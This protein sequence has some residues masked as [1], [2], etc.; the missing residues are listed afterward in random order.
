[1]PL[2]RSAASSWPS[3]VRAGM[4]IAM[5]ERRAGRGGPRRGRTSHP[6][7]RMRS[8]VAAT[9]AAS[10]SAEHADPGLLGVGLLAQDRDGRSGQ[11][12]RRHGRQGLE[13]RLRQDPLVRRD[14]GDQ[15]AEDVVDPV[16]ERRRRPEARRERDRVGVD[17]GGRRAGTGRCRPGGSGTATAWGR[18]R[19]TAARAREIRPRW[20]GDGDH[21]LEL[22]RVGVLVLVQQQGLVA[23]RQLGAH[24]LAVQRVAHE[25]PAEDEE[26]VERQP[27]GPAAALRPRP[28]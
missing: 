27:P 21:D 1:M 17:Q 18:R 20:R 28:G 22:Q 24:P 25:A 19:R 8:M 4:R 7:A 13:V 15:A 6:S 23:L 16:D 9:S 3:A 11:L 12:G 5:S 10:A 2:A 26:V 14:V